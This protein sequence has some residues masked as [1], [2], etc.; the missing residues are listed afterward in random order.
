MRLCRSIVFIQSRMSTVEENISEIV[1]VLSLVSC[2]L[3]VRS[4]DWWIEELLFTP[5]KP[6]TDLILWITSKAIESSLPS[7]LRL[8]LKLQDLDCSAAPVC[9]TS[10][11]K[12]PETDEAVLA[13][14]C[15]ACVCTKKDLP[16][17]K[18]DMP[19]NLQMKF[20][21][22]LI[23]TL[24]VITKSHVNTTLAF[25]VSLMNNIVSMDNFLDAFSM[26]ASL[27]SADVQSEIKQMPKERS[28]EWCTYKQTAPGRN[29]QND[30]LLIHNFLEQ[31]NRLN[32]AADQFNDVF[33][34]DLNVC[35]PKSKSTDPVMEFGDE[36]SVLSTK[37]T[38]WKQG[39]DS[40]LELQQNNASEI[41]LKK[42][43]NLLKH[44]VSNE[45]FVRFQKLW[46]SD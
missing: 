15:G 16:F 3:I 24:E 9:S 45:S 19:K 2:P 11:L 12:F 39:M 42:S 36:I 14:W 43:E 37:L 33:K 8:Q 25:G 18:G 30:K 27:L 40:L 41:N 26:K 1:N 21:I 28:E 22:R 31:A 5:G 20:W 7:N 13:F 17:I 34:A 38:A 4:D 46:G 44:S 10:T 23:K 6:R 32:S 29:L 35:L